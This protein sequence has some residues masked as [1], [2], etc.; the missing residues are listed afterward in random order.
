[1]STTALA[2]RF[3]S[4]LQS[5]NVHDAS[6]PVSP[7]SSQPSNSAVPA[8]NPTVLYSWRD[9]HPNARLI[10]TRDH[11]E[12]NV[13]LAQLHDNVYGFDLEWKPNFTKGAPE[14]PVALIQ[15]ANNKV[16]L[17]L[18]VTAMQEFPSKL[19]EFLANPNIIKAGVGIQKDAQKL[20]YD[21]KVDIRSCAD[22]T[23]LA[24]TV[25]ND[26]WKGK[27]SNPL[28][29]A[30]LVAA[31][32]DRALPKGKVTRSNWERTLN[33][34]QQLYAANDAH[35]GYAVYTRL[36]SMM[37]S[38]LLKTDTKYYSF[39]SIR[40]RLCDPSGVTWMPFNPNYDP[41]P[42]PPPNPNPKRQR[43]RR[44]P[45]A[46]NANTITNTQATTVVAGSTAHSISGP[47]A[48]SNTRADRTARATAPSRAFLPANFRGFSPQF[49]SN[50][51]QTR[52]F[53]NGPRM[54]GPQHPNGNWNT[55]PSRGGGRSSYSQPPQQVPREID[56]S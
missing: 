37:A 42:L 56:D 23:L 40:G 27:Y 12:A 14:N 47:Q 21:W 11:T 39:D 51:T 32:E 43:D 13:A 44:N 53:W 5:I 19:R 1:M 16:L 15:I 33:E 48:F 29:L 38:T 7:A 20:Y 30:R 49:H 31:Y 10:Y 9:I 2:A 26:K 4:D 8:Y 45:N 41:G 3:P 24:R 35:A 46:P 22:L 18:Q 36:M 28:G 54:Q 34:A 25:D 52:S 6:S 55:N 17:L 50:Y